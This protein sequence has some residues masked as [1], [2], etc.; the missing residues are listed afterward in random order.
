M[1]LA[2]AL[3]S[4]SLGALAW[5]GL[6]NSIPAALHALLRVNTSIMIGG[7]NPGDSAF[8]PCNQTMECG[9]IMYVYLRDGRTA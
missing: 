5:L 7:E 1:M 8:V 6:G 9:Y 3:L 4:G 2:Q